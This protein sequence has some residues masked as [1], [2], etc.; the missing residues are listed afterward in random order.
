MAM[1]KILLLISICFIT[2]S[3]PHI[4]MAEDDSEN[5]QNAELKQ[6]FQGNPNKPR[7]PSNSHI[8]CF[9][10]NGFIELSF[11]V[12]CEYMEVTL[13]QNGVSAFFGIVTID[14]PRIE[15]SLLTGEYII[16]CKTDGNQY[17]Q[18]ILYF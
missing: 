9:Y 8:N 4:L 17:Y 7:I 13:T 14:E 10:G 15:T 6:V 5:T 1:K 11:P 2:I 3:F 12:E 18:G 16:N